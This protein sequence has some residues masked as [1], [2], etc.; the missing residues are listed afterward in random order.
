ML[1]KLGPLLLVIGVLL[2]IGGFYLA[3]IESFLSSRPAPPPPSTSPA[4][5]VEPF[6]YKTFEAQ[7]EQRRARF[8]ADRERMHSDFQHGATSMASGMGLLFLGIL[9]LGAGGFVTKLGYLGAAAR[10][11][12]AETVPVA[13][14]A[15]D[16]LAEGGRAV[17]RSRRAGNTCM[18]C[19]IQNPAGARF[20][21]GCG[22]EL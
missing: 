4:S 18:A 2:L 8:E 15:F 14:D 7:Q 16:H 21:N 6:D 22:T 10:Y 19:N 11:V 12:A 1:R 3:F 20:C 9:L 5:A 13:R 17:P